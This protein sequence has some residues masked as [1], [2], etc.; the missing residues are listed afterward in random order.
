MSNYIAAVAVTLIVLLGWV[1]VQQ[2]SRLFTK[3]H[4][5]LG[6]STQ[7]RGGCGGGGSCLCGGG[8]C[9]KG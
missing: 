1:A 2:L 4:P 7:E 9:R 8:A 6:P 5:E 3:R